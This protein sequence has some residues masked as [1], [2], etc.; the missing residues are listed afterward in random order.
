VR[1]HD[2]EPLLEAIAD[3]SHEPGAEAAAHL[4]TCDVCAARLERARAIET[5]LAFREVAAPTPSFTAT[6]MARVGEE[7]WRTE[8]AIDIG[9][10]LAIA[11][12][13][14][15]I[16][17][18]GAGLAWSMGVLTVAIDLDAIWSALG[19]TDLTGRFLSQVQTFVL[20]A[21]ILTM[22]LGL[23]WWAEA[24]PDNGLTD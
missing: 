24:G 16:L 9:F 8:R 15:V 5:W 10:N 3:G 13:V 19:S 21:V 18:A 4:A 11:A 1:C 14:L 6:V 23:W 12:G 17:A 7:R 2:L 20:A 22:A